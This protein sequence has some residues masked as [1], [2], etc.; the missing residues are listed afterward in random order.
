[1]VNKNKV[2]LMTRL[3]AYEN[4]VGKKYVNTGHYFRGDYV[5]LQLIK[6]FV[7]GTL[8]YLAIVIVI[9]F[10]NFELFM[11]DVYATDLVEFGKK[12]GKTYLLCMGIYLVATYIVA[13]YRFRRAKRSL[14][15]Y[16]AF[17]S[18]LSKF[19]E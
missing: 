2:I 9:A 14:K 13:M 7:C 6:S 15:A 8:S 5:G 11:S 17:L 12:Q 16:N 4:G 19:D 3:A 18:R 1:M 10:Y